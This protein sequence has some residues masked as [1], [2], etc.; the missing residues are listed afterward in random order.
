MN[1][2]IVQAG[3]KGT[4]LGYLTK[5][6]PKALAPVDNLPMLFHLFRKYPDARFVIIGDYKDDVLR[7][8]LNSFSDVKYIVVKASGTGTC[9]GVKQS[10]ELIPRDEPFMLIWS[11]LILPESF[12]LPDEYING[13]SVDSDYVGLSTAF[14]CRWKYEDG[15]FSEERSFDF[16]VAGFF[17]FHDKSVLVDVPESGELVRWMRE[18]HLSFKTLS[19]AGTHEFG[20]LEEYEKLATVK[21]RP[22]NR[23]TIDGDVLTKEPVDEQGCEL[24]IR[25]SAWYGKARNLNI[26]G[27]PEIYNTAPLQMEYIKGRNIYECS[28]EYSEKRRILEKLVD[29]LK[30]LHDSSQI[31]SDAFSMKEAYFSKTMRRL[32][33]IEYLVPFAREEHIV[34]NGCECR[35]VFWHRDELEQAL[36]GLRC[37]CFSFI[38]G[39]CTFS[40]LMLRDDGS[41]ILIDPRGYFGFTEL[42]GDERYDWAKLYYS[43][44]GNYDRFNLKKFSLDIGGHS[45]VNGEMIKDLA[46]GEVRLAIESNGWEDMEGDFFKLTGCDE[47]EIK[48]LH[49]VIWLSLTTYAWQDYD[50]ICG[51]FYNG[52]YYFEEA[53]K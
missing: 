13:C 9:G 37:D 8:Y 17:L 39:D 5:N 46:P 7:E 16:G 34:V 20:L 24:A 42:Y 14:P 48:L 21:T 38:H 2:V 35:N 51:A 26:T 33:E 12:S 18:K 28:L 43:I 27:M 29:T 10:L 31:P 1:Y 36:D 25:E 32:S 47:H 30:G 11:D 41:P 53:L 50:S 15:E 44:V 19:L 45:V 22:F 3:G 49:A 40:N 23:I 4:R 6:K 52:L